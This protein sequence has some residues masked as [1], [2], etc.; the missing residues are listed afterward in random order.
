MIHKAEEG[1][2][3]QNGINWNYVNEENSGWFTL[4]LKIHRLTFRFRHRWLP[5]PKQNFWAWHY[6]TKAADAK[7]T[8]WIA[9]GIK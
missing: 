9:G 7:M 6:Q 8:E 2:A 5:E 4:G 1:Q 3:F